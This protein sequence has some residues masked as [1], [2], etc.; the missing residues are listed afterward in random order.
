MQAAVNALGETYTVDSLKYNA[1]K[2]VTKVKAT[3]KVTSHPRCSISTTKGW[4]C[5][6]ETVLNIEVEEEKE[7]QELP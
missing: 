4:K 3:S 5:L 6:G 2:Q 1:E 7:L